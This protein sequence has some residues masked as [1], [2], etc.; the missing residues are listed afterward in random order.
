MNKKEVVFTTKTMS[1]MAMFAALQITLEW[2]KKFTPQ[3][4]QGGSVAF[5]LIAIFLCSYIMGWGYG[6]IVSMV[7]VG[8]QFAL[9]LATFYGLVSLL[10]DY[11]I[12]MFLVG[13]TGII[14][15]VKYKNYEVPIGIVIIMILKTISHLISGWYAFKAPLL[16]NL[17]YNIPY[18]LATLLV[19][20]ILFMLLY[21]RLKHA[22]K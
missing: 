14:P 3:M 16:A 6:V 8:V 9:G 13:I 22:I 5:S 1:Y 2:I 19:C 20:F 17:G 4:P 11:F 10:L 15:L 12:A 7:C 18:N 21:P